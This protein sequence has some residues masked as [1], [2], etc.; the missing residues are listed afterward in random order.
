MEQYW[1]EIISIVIFILIS[2]LFIYLRRV[3]EHAKKL[4]KIVEVDR[5][6]GLMTITKLTKEVMLELK[7]AKPNEYFLMSFDVDNFKF[8]NQTYGYEKGNDL[9]RAIADSMRQYASEDVLLCRYHNDIFFVFGKIKN[10]TKFTVDA[11][12]FSQERCDEI[13]MRSGINT[14]LHFSISAYYI[15]DPNET[16]DY[17][18]QCVRSARVIAKQKYGNT[19]SIYTE[20]LR[21]K[22]EK[23]T[24]I[25]NAME[26]AIY[27]KEFFIL[28]QPKIELQT[29]KLVGGEVL[30]RWQKADGTCIYP[31]EFIP[32]F[33]NI[34]FIVILDKYVFE[35]TCKLIQSTKIPLPCISINVSAI[36]VLDEHFIEDYLCILGK[37]GLDSQQFELEI[38]ESS[39]SDNFDSIVS[40]MQKVKELGFKLAIDDLEQ[41]YFFDEPLS[42]EGFL[43]RVCEDNKKIY[44][45]AIE[46]NER[47]KDNE[48]SFPKSEL[49]F[50]AYQAQKATLTYLSNH[51][52]EYVLISDMETDKMVYMNKNAMKLFHF[53]KE[54]EWKNEFYYNVAFGSSDLIDESYNRPVT[55]EFS[56]R[57]YYNKFLNMYLYVE[58]KII[59]VLGK[60]MR[61]NI[62]TDVTTKKKMEYEHTLQMTLNQCVECL[63][64]ATETTDSSINT[65]FC[66]MLEHLRLYYHADRAYFYKFVI[67]GF[68]I[69]RFYEVLGEGIE[70]AEGAFQIFPEQVKMP[71][72][73]LLKE[74][75]AIHQQ[76]LGNMIQNLRENMSDIYSQHHVQSF[77]YCAVMDTEG[78][79]VGFIGVDN[80]KESGENTE[81]MLLLSRFVWMFIRNINAKQLE[82]ENY[83]LEELSKLTVLEK[84]TDNLKNLTYFDTNITDIL[85]LLR[86]HY[87]S[88]CALILMIS[89]DRTTYSVTYES[90]SSDTVLKIDASQNKPIRIIS[91]WIDCFERSVQSTVVS[92]DEL[93]L[94]TAERELWSDYGIRSSVVTPMYDKDGILRG[95][96]CINNSTITSRS[97][98]LIHVVAKDIFDYLEKIEIQK[99]SELDALTGVNNKII[100]Q[101][102]ISAL[103]KQGCKGV[104]L[105]L[106]TDHFKTINDTL[107]HSVGDNVLIDIAVEIKRIFRSDDIIGRIGGDE[108]MIFCPNLVMGEWTKIKAQ[109]LLDSCQKIYRNGDLSVQISVS[110]GISSVDKT[111]NTFTQLYEKADAALYE[112]KRN[113]R[114]GFS[115]LK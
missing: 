71:L 77:T 74:N 102:K 24:Q 36:T 103:L 10:S 107:G 96:L 59:T 29:G 101:E 41:G 11:P 106:D 85:Y 8:I 99:I 79:M 42:A 87:G 84:C 28:I 80:P 91:K 98:A 108:F 82:K 53:T 3:K 112:A 66:N 76:T 27:D 12:M 20:E 30:V 72:L 15:A 50:E 55:E 114:N 5:I 35:Q 58:N 92:I 63:Y 88:N 48:M 9:L 54:S 33:E 21:L 32:L 67:N 105:M 18:I 19:I 1:G 56:S 2:V 40:V 23:E 47:I 4:K 14:T 90:C 52:S 31:D 64:T 83:R 7:K 60:K 46:S 13:M 61:L 38:T 81:L 73:Q 44:P 111:C 43:D 65:T 45:D 110:I 16:L 49:S 22:I 70:S 89:E 37:Y 109:S 57:E 69:E 94:S 86:K 104:M 95:M 93:E 100:T 26:Q 113:G 75:K 51:S 39:L 97:H 17:M 62:I 6:T 68:E 25:Y 115:I 34:H 78:V